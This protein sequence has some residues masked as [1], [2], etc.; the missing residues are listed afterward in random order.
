MFKEL[1][2]DEAIE[3]FTHPGHGDLTGWA[4]QGNDTCCSILSR[5]TYLEVQR[6]TGLHLGLFVLFIF[7]L[8]PNV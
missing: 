5:A 1:T 4:Q 6:T 7:M 3:G 8:T 2:Q